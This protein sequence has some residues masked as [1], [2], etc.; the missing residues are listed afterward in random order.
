MAR[1]LVGGPI[2]QV[3]IRYDPIG[4][5]VTTHKDQGTELGLYG[6]LMR[7]TTEDSRLPGY[8]AALVDAGIEV[9]VRYESYDAPHPNFYHLELTDGY[10][11]SH[12][13]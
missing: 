10:G 12:R 2:K 1:D 13:R 9:E 4:S 3:V 8:A 5:L 7:W 11:I 6:G